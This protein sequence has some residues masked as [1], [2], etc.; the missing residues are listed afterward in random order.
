[1]C[2]FVEG[3]ERPLC[4]I[5]KVK[6]AL[7]CRFQDVGDARAVGYLPRTVANGVEPA[8]EREKCCSQ[9]KRKELKV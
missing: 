4:E 6:P 5:V 2:P 7:P 9:Q 3:P 8:Q 1:M